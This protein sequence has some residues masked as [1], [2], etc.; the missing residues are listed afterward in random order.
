MMISARRRALET[1]EILLSVFQRL[2]VNDLNELARVCKAWSPMAVGTKWRTSKIRLSRVLVHLAPFNAVRS[3]IDI[4][5]EKWDRFQNEY[6]KKV[7]ELDIDVSLATASRS[8][9]EKLIQAYGGPL[10][11]M[12]RKLRIDPTFPLDREDWWTPMAGLVACPTLG[13]VEIAQGT[14][15]YEDMDGIIQAITGMAPHINDVSIYTLVYCPTYAAFSEVTQL[16]VNGYFDHEA[17]MACASLPKLKSLTI[18]E[19]P[20]IRYYDHKVRWKQTYTVTFA[21]LA[22][23]RIYDEDEGREARFIVSI[24]RNAAMPLLQTIGLHCTADVDMALIR[25]YLARGSPLLHE[26]NLNNKEEKGPIE[27]VDVEGEEDE[28]GDDSSEDA[29]SE[30]DGSE[31]EDKV[32]DDSGSD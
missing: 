23:L 18:L 26:I 22:R 8:V 20:D 3:R 19:A 15:D 10:F 17:W 14:S 24:I 6:A 30:D 25:R 31:D 9:V 28:S 4:T 16:A 29:D 5:K 12:L 27:I 2:E 32:D 1:P 7:T 21:A 11:P 13:S